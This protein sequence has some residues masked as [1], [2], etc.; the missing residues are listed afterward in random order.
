[1]VYHNPEREC[2]RSRLNSSGLRMTKGFFWTA[3]NVSYQLTYGNR[4]GKLRDFHS[5]FV[6]C[7]L[8]L[9]FYPKA[10]RVCIRRPSHWNL[11]LMMGLRGNEVLVN[12]SIG[13]RPSGSVGPAYRTRREAPISAAISKVVPSKEPKRGDSVEMAVK[14]LYEDL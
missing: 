6:L 14:F 7:L 11:R 4:L 2:E 8:A 10:E 1:M 3:S 5:V 12:C 13:S 9:A